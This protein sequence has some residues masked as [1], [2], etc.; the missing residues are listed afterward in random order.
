M[1]FLSDGFAV[2]SA[3]DKYWR[4]SEPLVY[5]GKTD[6]F[7]VP[8]EYFTDFA[9]VPRFLHW[10]VSPYGVYTRAA[11]VHD[12]LL[13]DEVPAKRV[14]SRDADGIF[15]RIMAELGVSWTK[16][17][18]MWAAVRVGALFNP[19]RAYGR[20]FGKDALKVI[21]VFLISAPMI[22]PGAIGSA[23]SL[24]MVWAFN[25]ALYW[26]SESK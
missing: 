2:K 8:A 21:A 12:W 1:P 19:R 15:R 26:V 11:I 22:A 23:W 14:T 13:T 5:A 24:A 18:V 16:R 4:L 7:T 3:W 25:K 17:W 20:D 10:L 9:T 6:L